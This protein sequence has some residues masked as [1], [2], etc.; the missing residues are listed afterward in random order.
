[1]TDQE[2]REWAANLEDW[3]VA[4]RLAQKARRKY[5]DDLIAGKAWR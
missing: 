3:L 2:R 1:M 4:F 5:I